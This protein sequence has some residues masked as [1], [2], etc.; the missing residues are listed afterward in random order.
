MVPGI[1]LYGAP[2]TGKTHLVRGVAKSCNASVL[3]VSPAELFRMYIGESEKAIKALFSLARK[4]HPCIIFID[5]ADA[6]FRMRS[7]SDREWYRG[8]ISQL[9]QEWDGFA[10]DVSKWVLVILATNRPYDLDEAVL[11]RVPRKICVGLP[12]LKGREKILEIHL[13]DE[14][15]AEDVDLRS[16]AERTP[17]FTGSDLKNLCVVAAYRS[18][19][20]ELPRWNT[21]PAAETVTDP[22]SAKTTMEAGQQSQR[23]LKASHFSLAMQEVSMSVSK[24][25]LIRIRNFQDQNAKHLETGS[26]RKK[27]IPTQLGEQQMYLISHALRRN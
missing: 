8:I 2:G 25:S 1:L 12:S 26:T 7:D 5:E 16:I 22:K 21:P 18:I 27:L 13:R 4:L 24:D 14:R 15:L 3:D 17:D 11:R 19:Y 20:E 10:S 9:L 6:L 23:L